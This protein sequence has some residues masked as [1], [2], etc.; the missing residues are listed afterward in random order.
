MNGLVSIFFQ[1]CSIVNGAR[2]YE[3]E[4]QLREDATMWACMTMAAQIELAKWRDEHPNFT[5]AR[6]R[7]GPTGQFA[8]L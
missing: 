1:V 5:I 3:R 7:C 6:Y 8:K 4:I 2:C